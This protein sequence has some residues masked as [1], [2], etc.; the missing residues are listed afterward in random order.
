MVNVE[1]IYGKHPLF[2]A[3][4]NRPGDFLNIYTSNIGE[5]NQYINNNDI[6]INLKII[7]YKSNAELSKMVKSSV[8]HQGYLA[9]VRQGKKIDIYDF[10]NEKCTNNTDLPRLLILDGLTDPHNVGAIMRTA[11]AFGV[12]HVIKTERNSPKDVSIISKTSAGISELINIIEVININRT[13]E[14]LKKAGYFIVGL[15]EKSEESLK[16]MKN[17]NNLCVVVGSEGKGLRQLVRKN[18]DVLCS[19][20]MHNSNVDSLNASVAT[21]LAIYELW[22]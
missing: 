10:V 22:G 19:I 17:T 8:N 13:I 3:L 20:K 2:L 7:K 11:V 4:K 6:R 15:C 16:N 1:T 5:L 21:A 12:D 9:E 14:I 18:C